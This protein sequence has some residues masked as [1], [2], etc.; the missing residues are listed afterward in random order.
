MASSTSKN[1][2]AATPLQLDVAQLLM[3]SENVNC[4]E[5]I[6]K[7]FGNI[8]IRW[9]QFEEYIHKIFFLQISTFVSQ[10]QTMYLQDTIGTDLKGL[11]LIITNCPSAQSSTC[12]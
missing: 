10:L 2:A 9:M 12:Q 7:F 11:G 1:F 8:Y 4:L 6:L 3:L 5:S